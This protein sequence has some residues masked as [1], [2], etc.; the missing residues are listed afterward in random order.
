MAKAKKA[1]EQIVAD[2][3]EVGF[4]IDP[5]LLD[6]EGKDNYLNCLAIMSDPKNI[7]RLEKL[8]DLFNFTPSKIEGLKELNKTVNDRIIADITRFFKL[9]DNILKYSVAIDVIGLSKTNKLPD[10]KRF[11][12]NIGLELDN[13]DLLNQISD[14]FQKK[15]YDNLFLICVMN[16]TPITQ[17]LLKKLEPLDKV[18]SFYMEYLS[19][20]VLYKVKWDKRNKTGDYRPAEEHVSNLQFSKYL[21]LLS[22]IY[23][24][25]ITFKKKILY[26]NSEP[27]IDL[28]MS[29]IE[30]D[31]KTKSFSGNKKPVTGVYPEATLGY[32][33]FVAIV[34]ERDIKVLTFYEID[35]K[36]FSLDKAIVIHY[37]EFGNIKELIHDET[38]FGYFYY[39]KSNDTNLTYDTAYYVLTPAQKPQKD[40]TFRLMKKVK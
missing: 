20:D 6:L 39:V 33:E 27:I 17:Y 38:G 25:K 18:R 2:I 9:Q 7:E 26:L 21:N 32:A 40:L 8:I 13:F 5:N 19:F 30:Y 22:K 3:N 37:F 14:I 23:E 34:L 1:V 4:V 16:D 11:C 31:V 15:N 12:D 10:V 36:H 24:S 29:G 35:T 28:S